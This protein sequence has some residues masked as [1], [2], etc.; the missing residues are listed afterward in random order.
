MIVV[1][2]PMTEL[3]SSRNAEQPRGRSSV[4]RR[5]TPVQETITMRA[6]KIKFRSESAEKALNEAAKRVEAANVRLK[7][8]RHVIETLQFELGY[9]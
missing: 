9:N 4:R 6:R 1:T 5:E 3:R 7:S 2:I 8:E